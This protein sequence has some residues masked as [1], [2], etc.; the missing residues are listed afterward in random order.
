MNII[1]RNLNY[2]NVHSLFCHLTNHVII[3]KTYNIYHVLFV[4]EYASQFNYTNYIFIKKK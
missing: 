3:S 2:L 4:S 1:K